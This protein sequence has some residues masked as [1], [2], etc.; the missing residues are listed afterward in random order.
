MIGGVHI[1]RSGLLHTQR[2]L[3]T[4][5]H[6]TANLARD[7]TALWRT[8]GIARPPA[9]GVSSR[10]TGI[11]ISRFRGGIVMPRGFAGHPS[12]VLHG[13]LE[14]VTVVHHY[15]ALLRVAQ[16]QDDMLGQLVDLAA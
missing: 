5:A 11:G 6:N 3:E 10:T 13:A 14:Q 8:T 9:Q 15:A 1:T 12:P 2:R 7:R 4:S 16:T